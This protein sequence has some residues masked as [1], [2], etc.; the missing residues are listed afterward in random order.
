MDTS[1]NS[2]EMPSDA[3]VTGDKKREPESRTS[4]RD[5]VKELYEQFFGKPALPIDAFAHGHKIGRRV[6]RLF[7]ERTAHVQ[8]GIEAGIAEVK[9]RQAALG[10]G[11][12]NNE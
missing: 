8:R 11:G 12:E 2:R 7:P 5:R 1:A 4:E 10:A 6:A 9:E 3:P